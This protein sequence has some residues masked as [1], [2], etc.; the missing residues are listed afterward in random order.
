MIRTNWFSKRLRGLILCLLPL[1]SIFIG[2]A[3]VNGTFLILNSKL[4][5][6][7]QLKE[8][9]EC[10]TLNPI[11]GKGF[12]AN[13]A[14]WWKRFDADNQERVLFDIFFSTD[15]WGRRNTPGGVA[16]GRN[17][18]ALFFGCSYTLG[19]G[20][21]DDE[22]SPY[23]F[24]KRSPQF[25][26]YNYGGSGFGPQ[27]MLSALKQMDIPGQVE[28][29]VG[30]KIAIYQFLDFHIPRAV[31]KPN[32]YFTFAKYFPYYRFDKRG[33]LELVGTFY[34]AGWPLSKLYDL[35]MRIQ[36]FRFLLPRIGNS[37][38]EED[39]ALTAKIIEESRREF[40]KQFSSDEFYVVIY[41]GRKTEEQNKFISFLERSGTQYMDLSDMLDMSAPGA[42][43]GDGHP[44]AS[45]Q[46]I[47]GEKLASLLRTDLSTTTQR[48]RGPP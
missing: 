13:C 5:L 1:V 44:S 15:N 21:N 12:K 34:E 32:V 19:A 24:S 6:S 11:L 17:N 16:P 22:T 10:R 20:V 18:L 2:I 7:R 8:T 39:Y 42:R 14:S 33:E 36:V 47:V 37:I 23:F 48:T 35:L 27:Q 29:V 40:Q 28:K 46:K 30:R 45:T 25:D 43:V 38:H 4:K 3:L 26:V 9:F 41:P 31:G